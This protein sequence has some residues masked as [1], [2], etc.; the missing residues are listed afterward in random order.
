MFSLVITYCTPLMLNV[1]GVK[2]GYFFAAI[3]FVGGAILLLTVPEVGHQIQILRRSSRSRPKEGPTQSLMSF[4]NGEYQLG[5]S[6]R[7]RRRHSMNWRLETPRLDSL[8]DHSDKTAPGRG[9]R[10]A[11]IIPGADTEL[12]VMQNVWLLDYLFT[13]QDIPMYNLRYTSRHRSCP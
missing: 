9:V 7:P 3:S 4:S 12:I 10:R 5:N 11:E 13:S 8:S 2:T 1:W 6:L